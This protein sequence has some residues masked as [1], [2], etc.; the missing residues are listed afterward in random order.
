MQVLL[1][2][3]VGEQPLSAAHR[4]VDRVDRGLQRLLDLLVALEQAEHVLE[5]AD[6][7]G[8]LVRPGGPTMHAQPLV[9]LTRDRALIGLLERAR[10]LHEDRPPRRAVL[11]ELGVAQQGL[12]Q[13]LMQ[14]AALLRRPR[15]ARAALAQHSDPLHRPAQRLRVLE[16]QRR[17]LRV[18]AGVLEHADPHQL[19]AGRLSSRTC[20]LQ[21]VVRASR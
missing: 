12:G 7:A 19:A 17:R 10:G 21:P 15:V 13:R 6:R 11:H 20:P 5:L 18:L 9:D 3:R 16:P 8:S 1:Q 4:R 2:Q 14:R